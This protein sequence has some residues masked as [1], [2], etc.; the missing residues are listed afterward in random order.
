MHVYHYGGYE[1]GALKRL[2]QRHATR[3][4]EMDVLLRGHVLVDLYDHVVRQGIRAS[5]ES[6]S[7]KKLETFYMPHREGGIT[8]AGF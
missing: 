5:V 3:E 1:S 7:I 4:D 8:Q 6:Y 2:M